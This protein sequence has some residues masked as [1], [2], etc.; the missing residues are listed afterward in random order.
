MLNSRSS[1][2]L[3]VRSPWERMRVQLLGGILIAVAIPHVIMA[4]ITP[5][6]AGSGLFAISLVAA[7]GAISLGYYVFKGLVIFP[8]IRA[9]YYILPTFSGT[10]GTTFAVLLILRLDYSRS[11]LICSFVLCLCWY[12]IVYSRIQRQRELCIGIV[13]IGEI[14]TIRSIPTVEWL[15]LRGVPTGGLPCDAIVADFRADLPAEWERFLADVAL[16][17]VAVYD[18]KQLR[19]S[20][21][22]RVEISHFSEHAGGLLS[23]DAAYQK[24]K[25][26]IDLGF[27]LI[28]A[29]PVGLLLLLL[30][31]IIKLDSAGPVFFRQDRI[32]FRGKPFRIWKLRTMR[33]ADDAPVTGRNWAI[34]RTDDHRITKVGR[35]LRRLRLD[36]LPQIINILAGDMSWIGPR[37]EALVLSHWYQ[38]EIPFYRYRHVVRP[39]I[40]G[41]AQ[42]NLGHV[43]D[44]SEVTGKLHYDF[45]YIA[46]FSLWIDVLIAL[47]TVRIIA[48][49]FGAK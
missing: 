42:V 11:L 34:T 23:P 35:T 37:P 41:W 32:G 46:N 30:A 10:F 38:N 8:G 28:L 22:G 36:E 49:G 2:R 1:Y 27:T 47:R 26:L 45:Y 6:L 12:Y 29:L 19:D 40:T 5:R 7:I 39:G 21:T 25:A 9:S 13:P 20:L 17:G 48:T 31:V 4:A 24:A 16:D 43:S 14:E 15:T 33:L 44:V 18:V 3:N